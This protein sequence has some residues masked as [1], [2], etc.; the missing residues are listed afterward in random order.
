[1]SLFKKSDNV[2]DGLVELAKNDTVEMLKIG[3]NMFIVVTESLVQNT[4]EKHYEDIKKTD[5]EI[6]RLQRK[7]R[8]QV[9]EHLSISKG[10]DLFFSLILLNVVDDSERIGDYNKNIAEVVTLL[11]HKLELGNYQSSFDVIF[12][13]TRD[14]F[15]KTIMA[16]IDDGE[17]RA[18]EILRDY[19]FISDQCDDMIETILT[20]KSSKTVTKDILAFVL[21]MRFFK[22]VNAHLK[23][24]ASTVV[25]PFDRIG[26]KYKE[27]S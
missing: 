5:K 8:R 3:W 17:E 18:K 12:K 24:I 2:P 19:S 27:Q 6:N 1:M 9:F 11:P 26:Y 22:R 16:F 7:V 10:K 14:N 15:D 4:T 21:L 20:D 23:N 13:Q 25:N